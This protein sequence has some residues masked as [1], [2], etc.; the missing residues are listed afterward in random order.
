MRL[1]TLIP[2]HFMYLYLHIIHSRNTYLSPENP[3]E[4]FVVKRKYAP[5]FRFEKAGILNASTRQTASVRFFA[6][7][8]SAGLAFSTNNPK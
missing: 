8:G 6:G 7:R 3:P 1:L 5:V 2:D 4:L